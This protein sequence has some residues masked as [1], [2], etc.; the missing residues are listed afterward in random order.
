MTKTSPRS[1]YT[2][3]QIILHWLIAALVL[4]NYIVSDGM[5][6]ALRRHLNGEA[7]ADIWPAIHVYVGIAV[8]VLVLIRLLLR[9]RVGVPATAEATPG[10]MSRLGKI[11]HWLIYALLLVGPALG[12]ATWYLRLGSAG[13]LHAIAMNALMILAGLHA[14]AGIYHHYVVRDGLLRRMGLPL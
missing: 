10:W 7:Q 9:R 11:G 14:A 2:N 5:G 3:S 6:S 12:V 4:F 8:L 13:D 1:G